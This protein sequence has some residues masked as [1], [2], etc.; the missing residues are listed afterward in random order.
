MANLTNGSNGVSITQ[1]F[2]NH[3]DDNSIVS[4]PGI[5]EIA[6]ESGAG[7][8]FLH[9]SYRGQGQVPPISLS[10]GAN[11]SQ[12]A[13]ALSGCAQ[14]STTHTQCTANV[15]CSPNTQCIVEIYRM[16]G[17]GTA[18]R[19]VGRETV[20]ADSTGHGVITAIFDPG[21]NFNFATD[22]IGATTTDPTN[23]TSQFSTSVSA[24][25]S[26]IV[27][28]LALTMTGSPNPAMNSNITYTVG[29]TNN[30]PAAA[31]NTVLIDILP[32]AVNF[33]SATS[34]TG[35]CTV[36][37]GNNVT[38]NLGSLANGGSTTI[39][40]V[41]APTA[42]GTFGNFAG[43]SSDI[44]DNIRTNNGVF[45]ETVVSSPSAT[46]TPTPCAFTLTSPIF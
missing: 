22:K 28:D 3:C 2:N 36:D 29:V 7:D 1:G 16:P 15:T 9:N 24:T 4:N 30:G 45:L 42:T 46:P 44:T 8:T 14:N 18:F 26:S 12:A 19:R 32:L 27:T 5:S 34:T 38:C 25:P 31:P 10:S 17:D 40:I 39:T 43:V 6:L 11:N 21:P 37:A 35:N 20:T 13:P 23:G 33:V 41:V